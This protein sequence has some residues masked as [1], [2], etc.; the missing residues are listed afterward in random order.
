MQETLY[1][2]CCREK[3]TQVDV[4]RHFEAK[5][6]RHHGEVEGVD[7]VDLFERVGVVGP[8][9]RLVGFL[10]R[11]VQVVVLLNQ[12]LQLNEET[13]SQS[14]VP[15]TVKLTNSHGES[16]L[17]CVWMSEILLHE[18]SNSLSGT[19]TEEDGE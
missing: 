18:N 5:G 6:Q 15:V 3:D 9:V 2:Q 4:G 12:L 17:T 7:A 11:L 19:W 10:G 13:L 1:G 14:F 8:H 16:W